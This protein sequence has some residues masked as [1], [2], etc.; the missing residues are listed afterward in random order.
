M[1]TIALTVFAAALG[2]AQSQS[3]P[4][5]SSPS[6][7][8]TSTQPTPTTK[9][10]T[11]AAK[12]PA[13]APAKAQDKKP[14][15]PSKPSPGKNANAQPPV[16]SIPA[17]AVEVE[18]YIYRFTDAGGKTWMYRETPFGISRWEEASTPGPQASPAKGDSV[19]VTDLGDS[20]RF[21]KKMP[22]GVGTW[23]RKKT[24]LNDEEKALVSGSTSYLAP[25]AKGEAV[26]AT[27]LGDSVRFEK[28]TPFGVE[29]W[30]RKKTELS[31]EEKAL[32][33]GSTPSSR[34]PSSVSKQP[35]D[36]RVADKTK[37]DK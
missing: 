14:P 10:A 17:G 33:S 26:V 19:V 35:V 3:S 20:V 30:V 1:K 27:D 11:P 21:E 13:K 36:S 2:I 7:S 15:Q 28:K 18:P 32:L 34:P 8:S 37:E 6:T 12:A 5:T 23:V 4:S 25:A 16:L 24:E 29:S 9:A 31:D 22:F